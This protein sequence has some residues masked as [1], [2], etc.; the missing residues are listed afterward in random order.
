[1]TAPD[2]EPIPEQPP[3]DL[4]MLDRPQPPVYVVN[5]KGECG[6]GKNGTPEAHGW[7]GD[8]IGFTCAEIRTMRNLREAAERRRYVRRGVG[9]V[10]V[11]VRRWVTAQIRRIGEDNPAESTEVVQ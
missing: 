6:C 2:T 1:M 7:I 4:D 3:V 11:R 5:D 10:R 9:S 8:R